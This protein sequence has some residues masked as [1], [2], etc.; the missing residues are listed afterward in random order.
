MSAA[1][2][3]RRAAAL[4]AVAVAGIALAARQSGAILADAW[5]HS[6]G[7]ELVDILR[8]FT[9]DDLLN[10]L[11]FFLVLGAAFALLAVL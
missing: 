4:I 5:A 9:V 2:P 11:G 1:A 3:A 6:A 7:P 8:Q 10:A